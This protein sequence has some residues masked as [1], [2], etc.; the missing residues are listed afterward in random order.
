MALVVKD[1]VQ[2]ITA[3]TGTGTLTLGG[4]VL[5]FQSFAAIGNGNTT[6][7]TIFD[8]TAGD[9]EVGIGTYTASGTTLSRDTVLSSSN[10]GSLVP[11]GAGTKNVICTYPSER[12]VYLDSPGSYPVQS[13][14]NTL[15]AANATLAAGTVAAVP[16]DGIDIANKSYVDTT[17]QGLHIHTPVLVVSTSNLTAAYVDGG[18]TPTWTSITGTNTVNTGS[19]HGLAENDVIV[20]GSTTNGITAGTA[21]FVKTVPS[22]TSITL[23]YFHDGAEIN[24]L[25]AGSVSITSRANSG[26]GATLTNSGT[27][28]ALTIDGV[29]LA[30]TN[31]VLVQGQTTAYQNGVYTVTNIGSGS[32]NWVLTRSSDT[33]K[34]DP[35]SDT[36]LGDGDYFFVQAGNTGKGDSYVLS[37]AG[38]IVFGTTNLT[39]NQFSESDVYSA[40]TGLTLS[41]LTFSITNTGVTATTYGS[42]SQVPVFAVNAQGQLTSVTDTAIAIS[43]GAVSGLAA[44]ATTDTTNA[45]NISSGTLSTSRLSG[46]YTGIS[47]VGTLTAGT[48]NATAIGPTYGGTGFTSYAIGDIVYADTTTSLAKLPDVA[49]GNALISGGVGAAPS[50]GKIGLATHVSG[51]LPIGSGGTG[52]TTANTAFNALVPSQ[53]GNTG[54]YLT[55]DGSNTSWGTVSLTPAAVSDQANTSTGFFG[56]PSGTTA[57]RPGSPANGY[58]RFNTTLNAVE[59]Y[60]GVSSAWEIIVY[61]STPAAPTIGTAT[62]TGSTTA[63]VTYTAPTYPAGNIPSTAITSYTAVSSP[64]GVTG[65]VTQ[66]GS[67]TITVTG[68]TPNTSYTFTVYATNVTGNSASS[69]ASNSITTWALPGA[70]TIG[71]ASFNIVAGTASVPFTAPAF[72]GNTPITSYTAVSSPGGITGTLS[73]A[74][75]GTITVSGLTNYTAYTFTVYATNAVGNGPSS[76]ASNSIT[77]K[78]N[79]YTASYV[80]VAGGG[81]GGGQNGGGGGAGGMLTG[82]STLTYGTVYSVTVGAGGISAQGGNSTALGLTLIGGGVGTG[83]AGGSGAGG[84][85]GA[86][87]AGTAGQGN[88]G[89][90]GINGGNFPA[91]GGGGK[92]AAGG[93]APNTS[94]GGNGGAGQAD[95]ITGASVTY[96]GGGGGGVNPGT[97]GTG[98][99]GG[100][101]NGSTAAS[102][103]QAGTV[104][105][106]GG[107]GGGNNNRAG[108]GGSGI[109]IFSV[110]TGSYTGTTTGS[111]TITTNGSNTVIKFTQ[112]GSYT[113]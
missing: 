70:P 95:S 58:T 54:K 64:G 61:F 85:P 15:T 41:S 105:T 93:N 92:G 5:G 75:S 3:T 67:G 111:P 100:G 60:S 39:F 112:S 80:A 34:Y 94:T 19:A 84:F 96:A 51:T 38:T 113:A 109:V 48:W 82:T 104:N 79:T 33:N 2:E 81:C 24:T 25:T 45:S 55:T 44:S 20:F 26:V 47:G 1:R 32:T 74:G 86:G 53:T 69:A 23:A 99:A 28:V 42:A 72:N 13:T 98:G 31:R 101:G 30:S 106:G 66:A 52:Q 11:F 71:T 17:A 50:W 68:L 6:Y 40:G 27:Q 91:G 12:A 29:A 63:T 37:T 88:N 56:L 10:A 18:T 90:S 73:Q 22:S 7:Y 62:V 36:G 110:P 76:A 89:G 43:A 9:W 57:Q 102:S 35:I 4:A 87:G 97:G 78:P 16:V 46:S 14:F 49:V 83:G 103:P 107:G 77:P 8:L 108:T 65:T 59:C 21:Y